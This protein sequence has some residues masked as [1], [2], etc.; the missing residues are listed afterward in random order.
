MLVITK[1]QLLGMLKRNHDDYL[2]NLYKGGKSLFRSPIIFLFF[3]VSMVG[4][5]AQEPG[6]LPTVSAVCSHVI[7]L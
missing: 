2:L 4:A 1:K 6:L 5:V 7:F 3:S